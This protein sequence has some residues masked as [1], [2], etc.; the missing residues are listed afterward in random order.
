MCVCVCVCACVF[1]SPH[2]EKQ[3]ARSKETANVCKIL[4]AKSIG[5]ARFSGRGANN[6]IMTVLSVSSICLTNA[7][8]RM[9]SLELLMMDGKT[10]RNM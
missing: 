10:V 9:Y 3:V 5:A 4:V 2:T 7:C 6:D 1:V 8:C